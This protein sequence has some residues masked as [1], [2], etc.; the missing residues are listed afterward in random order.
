[1]NHTQPIMVCTTAFGMG[2]DQPD[3]RLVFH[4]DPP[5][6]PEAYYQEAGRAGRDGGH[7]LCLLAWQRT[8]LQQA[9]KRI[10][11]A[12]PPVEQIQ[13][14]YQ[15]LGQW[16]NLAVGGGL[17]QRFAFD[18]SAFC[19][20]FDLEQRVVFHALQILHRA[21][22]VMAEE[23]SLLPARIRFKVSAA[24]LYE[25]RVQNPT[26]DPYIDLLLRKHP[27]ILDH[28]VRFD[29]RRLA[30]ESGTTTVAIVQA[31]H[32][33]QE[34]DLLDYTPRSDL[35]NLCWLSERLPLSHFY[36]PPQ[37]YDD[38]RKARLGR[39][40]AMIAM[41][42][43]T[44]TCRSRLML[45]YFGDTESID[46]GRCDVCIAGTGLPEDLTTQEFKAWVLRIKPHLNEPLHPAALRT[47]LE[48]EGLVRG[49]NDWDRQA[50]AL[51]WLV[52]QGTILRDADDRLLWKKP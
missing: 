2:I 1:M 7:G 43:E 48:N 47:L 11:M 5:E 50:R 17:D 49:P 21:N 14:I 4:W 19:L 9:R 36:L 31:V 32:R 16:C 33:M 13:R 29:E 41:M 23:E 39:L 20:R 44:G 18:L 52:R 51:S 38:L 30:R 40:E 25:E 8:D 42:T 22:L 15:A 12:F 10:E 6:S 46:C 45:A 34:R 35:Q 27:G 3:V 37:A 26:L 24:K 28:P